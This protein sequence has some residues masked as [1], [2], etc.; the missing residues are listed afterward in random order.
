M[1]SLNTPIHVHNRRNRGPSL[2][3]STR[4]VRHTQHPG[5]NTPYAYTL[6]VGDTVG[7]RST[8]FP[9]SVPVFLLLL[10]ATLSLS[11][12]RE[13]EIA[14]A[15][16]DWR[17]PL[18]LRRPVLELLF[19]ASL[20]ERGETEL[21]TTST[22]FS[23][24]LPLPFSSPVLELLLPASLAESGETELETTSTGLLWRRGRVL[25]LRR[26]VLELLLPASLA[27]RGETELETTSTGFSWRLPLP[28]S[29]PVLE[30]LLPASLAESGETE[31]ETTSTGLS[32]GEEVVGRELVPAVWRMETGR[33]TAKVVRERR[34]RRVRVCIVFGCWTVG[35]RW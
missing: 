6:T 16:L 11:G 30:L 34:V 31:L 24:R 22:G 2:G 12:L 18:P 10:P 28:F 4:L 33:E 19:P 5:T 27:E 9:S 29:S 32:E 25:P 8:E 26:P 3:S 15:G 35:R 20:A 23:W 17:L 21:E 13:L 14:S 7:L 1:L